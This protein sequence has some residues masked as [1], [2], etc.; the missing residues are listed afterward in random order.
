MSHEF[1]ST[2]NCTC[3]T[4]VDVDCDEQARHLHEG[5]LLGYCRCGDPLRYV[6]PPAGGS[7][8][9]AKLA[10]AI[11]PSDDAVF[12]EERRSDYLKELKRY[13]A[14]PFSLTPPI[15]DL[16]WIPP[17]PGRFE[18]RA[19]DPSGPCRT[20]WV[21][22][23]IQALPPIAPPGSQSISS[24]DHD[25]TGAQVKKRS[26]ARS[27]AL[28]ATTHLNWRD[29]KRSVEAVLFGLEL[30]LTLNAFLTVNWA[31]IGVDDEEAMKRFATWR[32][33]ANKWLEER[34]V[35]WAGLYVWER[36]RDRGLHVHMLLHCPPKHGEAFRA[37]TRTVLAEMA[38]CRQCL[39]GALRLPIARGDNV[40]TQLRI[41]RYMMKGISPD[42]WV[43]DHEGNRVRL[44]DFAKLK[45]RVAGKIFGRR[46]GVTE[47]LGPAARRRLKF[48]SPFEGKSLPDLPRLYDEAAGR[49]PLEH[50]AN[51][52]FIVSGII[53]LQNL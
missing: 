28:R 11:W 42:V 35:P 1:S 44:A 10:R 3:N 23:P 50:P 17:T 52:A 43:R 37:W 46:I 32:E 29:Y 41:L 18:S 9:Y 22:R 2:T 45:P 25:P 26:P 49:L 5:G 14:T 24:V 48:L 33:R 6:P 12:E 30:G 34:D 39:V 36:G 47:F 13:Q 31:L 4:A 51:P 38:G 8:F 7:S 21:Q 40:T 27:R 16:I 15:L 19:P 20:Q 53:A